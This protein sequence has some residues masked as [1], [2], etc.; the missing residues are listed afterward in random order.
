MTIGQYKLL[1]IWISFTVI[2]TSNILMVFHLY[3]AFTE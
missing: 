1:A 3:L 2:A